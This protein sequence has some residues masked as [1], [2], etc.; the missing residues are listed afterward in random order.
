MSKGNRKGWRGDSARH[1]LAAKGI[2]TNRG[3][4]KVFNIIGSPPSIPDT[5]RQIRDHRLSPREWRD[6]VD[7]ISA[8]EVIDCFGT[9][10]VA[11]RDRMERKATEEEL[12]AAWKEAGLPA[13]EFDEAYD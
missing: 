8:I 12:R 4:A 2:R 3:N 11:L 10:D 1:A 13:E 5:Y 6:L 9:Y 7:S